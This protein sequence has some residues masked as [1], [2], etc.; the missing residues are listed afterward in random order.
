MNQPKKTQ[1]PVWT[2]KNTTR[3]Q[4]HQNPPVTFHWILVGLESPIDLCSVSSLIYSKTSPGAVLV[5]ASS[6]WSTYP[7]LMFSLIKGNPM[8]NTNKWYTTRETPTHPLPSW[9]LNQPIWKIFIISPSFEVNIKQK[10]FE[11][12]PP[13]WMAL[14]EVRINGDQINGS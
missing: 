6:G 13:T 9:W 2:T 7:P 5:T 12:T 11:L 8:V 14:R 3:S 4:R 1:R 10:L